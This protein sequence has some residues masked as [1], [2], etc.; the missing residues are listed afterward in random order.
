MAPFPELCYLTYVTQHHQMRHKSHTKVLCKW[1]I[2]DVKNSQNIKNRVLLRN[3]K[4]IM[5][6]SIFSGIYYRFLGFR[7]VLHRFYYCLY[8]SLMQ[9]NIRMVK[10]AIFRPVFLIIAIPE[11]SAFC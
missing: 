6:F 8:V 11:N 7:C 9:I 10:A 4:E 3:S 1:Q 2:K 5:L